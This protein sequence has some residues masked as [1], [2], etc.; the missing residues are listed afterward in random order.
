MDTLETLKTNLAEVGEELKTLKGL[1]DELTDEQVEKYKELSKKAMKLKVRIDGIEADIAASE[2][3]KAEQEAATQKRIDD[4]VNEA[5]QR[6]AAKNRRPPFLEGA[7]YVAQYSDTYKYDHLDIEELALAVDLGKSMGVEFGAGAAKALSL[8]V[9]ALDK[10]ESDDAKRKQIAYVKTAFKAATGILPEK[11]DVEKAIKAATDPMYTGASPM[12]DWVGTAYSGVLWEKIRGQVAIAQKI[13][14]DV[15]PDGYSSKYWP[16]ESTDFTWY[17]TAEASSSDATLKV[18]AATVTV[19]QLAT[20]SKQITIGKM[21]ARGLYTE[22]ANE[23]SL[24]AFAPQAR[25]QLVKS[26]AEY[27]EHVLIDGD[28]E[29]SANKNINTIASTP[30]GTEPYLLF[31]GFRKLALVTNTAN[32]RSAGAGFAVEDYKETLRLL[33][34]AGLAGADPTM[35]GFIQDFNVMWAALEIPELKTKDVHSAATIEDGF[36]RR[37]Y[38]VPV[39]DSYFMHFLSAGS[40]YERRANTSGK[41]D[42]GTAANN[43]SG[44]ILA[45]RFDQWK[46]AYKRR[47]TIEVERKPEFDGYAITAWMRFGFAYRDTEACAITY[48]VGV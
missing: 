5:V 15:V 8:K 46:L 28:V 43:S 42:Q 23:D 39:Y 40:G 14:S 22:E 35:V 27:L 20:G 33:G 3:A 9:A 25:D 7:P 30:A 24:I 36:L 10:N 12:S 41:I 13:P 31:D 29:T 17:K 2:V 11:E 34:T 45:V 6:E 47:M 48:N 44:S 32:S 19:S 16:L 4:A 18:P 38:R 21:G 26:G 1:G 37:V